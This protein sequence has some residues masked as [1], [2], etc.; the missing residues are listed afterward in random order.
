MTAE[1]EPLLAELIHA[2][3]IVGVT[4]NQRSAVGRNG[5]I[6]SG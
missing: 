1:R 2:R 6:P 4:S 3:R 5:H